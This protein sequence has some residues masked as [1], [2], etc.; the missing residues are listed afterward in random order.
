VTTRDELV[1]LTGVDAMAKALTQANKHLKSKAEQDMV[2]TERRPVELPLHGRP[3]RVASVTY[4][5]GS[6]PRDRAVVTDPALFLQWVAANH[7]EAIRQTVAEW[8]TAWVAVDG[9]GE[10]IP[11]VTVERVDGSQPY[12]KVIHEKSPEA[13]AA[14]FDALFADG[15]A[16]LRSLLAA[17]G[18]IEAG[19]FLDAANAAEL[20]ALVDK[21]S[22]MLRNADPRPS[23][24]APGCT[25]T[26]G[27]MGP[28]QYVAG[29]ACPTA[30]TFEVGTALY[31]TSWVGGEYDGDRPAV[32]VI[33]RPE[34]DANAMREAHL[35]P[36]EARLLA[37][38]LVAAADRLEAE[39]AR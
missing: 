20:A 8:F 2:V 15:A 24:C 6:D 5:K 35:L 22:L 34:G 11:G 13:K 10:E 39:A 4:V 27:H 7:P 28:A 21:G 26:D 19:D 29:T 9:D 36:D 23:W 14:L 30:P 18:Q 32:L 31:D 3:V 37:Q 38:R 12:V 1:L 17:I 16:G 25:C 33:M